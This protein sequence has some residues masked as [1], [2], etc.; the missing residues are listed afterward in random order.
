MLGRPIRPGTL[1]DDAWRRVAHSWSRTSAPSGPDTSLAGVLGPAMAVP[2]P[3]EAGVRGSLFVLRERGLARLH[4]V[5]PRRRGVL[6]RPRR[7][8]AGSRRRPPGPRSRGDPRGP[9]PDRA[10]PPRPRRSAPLRGRAEH[11]ERAA[12][13]LGPGVAVD[14]LSDQVDEI[15]ATIRQ[16]RSTIFGLH[17]TR[18][19]RA[20]G[21]RAHA[22]R[23][24]HGGHRDAGPEHPR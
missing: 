3:A 9:G 17:A 11:P 12:A 4:R 20:G 16:I 21:V 23:G 2:L 7:A 8:G 10:G 13:I 24:H 1:S 19:R 18:H 5:R 15:D 14:R 6:R 22:P